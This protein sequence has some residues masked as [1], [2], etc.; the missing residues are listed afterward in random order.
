[1]VVAA[2]GS[3]NQ[4]ANQAHRDLVDHLAE[5]VDAP[6]VAAFL[7]LAEPS[8]PVAIDTAIAD[9]DLTVR[10]LPYFLH[11]GRHLVDDLPR[12]VAEA[13]VRHPAA[14][15]DLLDSFGADPRLLDLLVSQVRASS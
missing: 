12:I 14:E 7:E 4:L 5:L 15:V 2:H 1:M 6:V 3:R 13:R 8:I 11:P 10:V 9:G